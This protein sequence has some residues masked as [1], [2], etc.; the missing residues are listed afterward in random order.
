MIQ[1]E[2]SYWRQCSFDCSFDRSSDRGGCLVE[3]L[4]SAPTP[5][6]LEEKKPF[7]R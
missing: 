3:K 4:A 7:L 1:C 5:A 2:R 6:R